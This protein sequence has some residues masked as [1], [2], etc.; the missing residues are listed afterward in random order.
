VHWPSPARLGKLVVRQYVDTAQ[1]YTVVLVD[2]RPEVYSADSFEEAMD[3]TASVVA[4]TALGEAPVQLRT[5][6]GERVGGTRKS[7]PEDLVD[8][9]T[10]L[11]PSPE[12][13]LSGQLV[14]LRRE[15]GGN[16]LVVVTGAVQ[17][18]SLPEVAALRRSFAHVVLVS[19]VT[20]PT[21]APAYAGLT[22]LV[23]TDAD[24]VAEVW[25]AQV[26]K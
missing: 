25:D 1:P 10:D 16:A 5:T 8:F 18:D 4:A 26:A 23:G 24:D 12:G 20:R 11:A 3:V 17:P 19:L 7:N 15:K 21:P 9:L 13:S 22:I 14:G 6:A 2:L